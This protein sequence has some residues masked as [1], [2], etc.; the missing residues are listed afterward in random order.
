MEDNIV[1]QPEYVEKFRCDGSRC[2]SRC[3]G[4]WC[5]TIDMDAYKKY[6]KVKNTVMRTKILSVIEPNVAGQEFQIKLR[7]NGVCP[8]VCDDSLCYIQRN[9]GEDA[10]SVTFWDCL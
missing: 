6:Q 4:N 1:L 2:N 9:L 7:D 5:I 10:L 8:M 3:C